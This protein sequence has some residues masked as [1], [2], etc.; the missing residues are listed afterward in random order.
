VATPKTH[1]RQAAG[2]KYSLVYIVDGKRV[3]GY[4]NAENRG[5]HRHYGNVEKSYRFNSLAQLTQDFY[6]DVEK[7]KRG[8]KL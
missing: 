6:R 8:D 7:Y 3:I 1:S 4:D 2:Y 5:D